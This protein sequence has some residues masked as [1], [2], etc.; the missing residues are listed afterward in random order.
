MKR[1]IR[2]SK[3]RSFPVGVSQCHATLKTV[4][5]MQ[6]TEQVVPEGEVLVVPEHGGWESPLET[7]HEFPTGTR[8]RVV[9]AG[10]PHTLSITEVDM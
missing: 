9:R 1:I 6:G 8:F 10:N 2:G 7:R 5:G 3:P 4:Y